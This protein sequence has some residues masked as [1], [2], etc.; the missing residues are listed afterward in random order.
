MAPD[1][2]AVP[3]VVAAAGAAGLARRTAPWDHGGGVGVQRAGRLEW[4][5]GAELAFELAAA[6]PFIR[7]LCFDQLGKPAPGGAPLLA[8]A[9]R[10]RDFCHFCCHPLSIHIEHTC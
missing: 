2:Q 6:P 1:R 3:Y 7:L 5:T 9:S 10:R 4:E 8:R